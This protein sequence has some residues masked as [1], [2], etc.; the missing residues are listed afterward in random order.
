MPII[1]GCCSYMR[2]N[3]RMLGF[4]LALDKSTYDKKIL[5]RLEKEIISNY[6]GI[7]IVLSLSEEYFKCFLEQVL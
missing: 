7:Y 2:E 1:E 5:P 6:H 3:F 4:C